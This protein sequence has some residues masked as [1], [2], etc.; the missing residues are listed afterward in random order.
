[1]Q[2]DRQSP[3]VVVDT[4][5]SPHARLRPLPVTAVTFRDAF[6]ERRR[7]AVREVMLPAQYDKL[8][9]T[10]RLTNFR[11]AAAGEQGG[12][13]GLYFNDTDV[14]KWLE[15]AAWALAVPPGGHPDPELDRLVDRVVAEVAAAQRPDGYLDTFYI[16]GG[17]E[18]R[19]TE[20]VRTHELYCAGHLIQAAVAHHRATGK[21]N[22]FE[23][24][25]RFAD[26]V[27]ASLGPA[28]TGRRPG[29]DGHE[30][31]EMALVE[32]A[33]ETGERRY[34]EQAAYFIDARGRGLAGGD[35]Y[36]QDH[37]P[38]RE[39][40]EIVGHAVRAV[41]LNAGAA[42]LYAETGER[43][44]LDALERLW[45]NLT[46]GRIYPTGGIGARYDGEAFGGD[47]EL[48]NARAYAETCAAIGSVMW[49]WRMLL[50]TGEARYADLIEL[51]L[52]NAILCGISIDNRAYYYEN[53]L[54]DDGSKRRHDWFYCSCCPPNVARTF[55]S[56]PGYVATTSDD[57]IWVHLYAASDVD[58]TLSDGRRVRLTQRTRYPWDGSVELAVDGAGSFT[59][60]LR[61]PGWCSEGAGLAVNGEP[62]RQALTPGSFVAIERDWTPGDIV[63]LTLPMVVR[64]VEAH[65]YVAENVG[66]VA[67]FRGPIL[68]C[69]E[70][71]DNPGVDPRDVALDPTAE[72]AVE[73][74]ADLLH[75]VTLLRTTGIVAPVAPG[76]EERI[77]RPA[78]AGPRR[79]AAEPFAVTLVPYFAWGNREH[80]PMEVWLRTSSQR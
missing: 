64:A 3:P 68:Y 8:E 60:F 54:S 1:M 77:Y 58:L 22:L 69:A 27:C 63:H 30:E 48:P 46:A 23:V 70:R 36:H 13:E 28:E 12:F 53:P 71:A 73:H 32:L 41:Y 10:G 5:K 50:L 67:L 16:L 78:G 56:L 57:G 47:H 25:C 45:R 52:Y 62:P 76:W 15:A 37:K 31:I 9:Q 35:E 4:S 75:G 43:A 34:L 51:T 21:T 17:L 40:D 26:N 19:W 6:W 24:A 29:T 33:R 80:G 20:L 74:R 18:Q 7:Q 72:F 66:K 65:P 39:L 11:R 38:F 59:L 2:V 61:V 42:D 14:Y 49:N 79:A 44:L 55:A